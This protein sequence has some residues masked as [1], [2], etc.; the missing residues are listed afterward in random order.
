M[1]GYIYM[2]IENITVWSF[3]VSR[4]IQGRFKMWS[5]ELVYKCTYLIPIDLLLPIDTSHSATLGIKLD[6]MSCGKW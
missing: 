1:D 3:I 2:Y 4:K 6:S 5:E